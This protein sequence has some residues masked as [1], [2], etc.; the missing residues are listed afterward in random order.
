MKVIVPD[1]VEG[2][3]C[4][5]REKVRRGVGERYSWV[6]KHVV[7]GKYGSSIL[8]PSW[9]FPGS[10]HHRLDNYVRYLLCVL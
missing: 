3:T 10:R 7:I 8:S 9:E 4:H 1:M 6:N 2:T 5:G